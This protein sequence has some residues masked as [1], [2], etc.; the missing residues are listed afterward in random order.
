MIFNWK[1][2]FRNSVKRPTQL[3]Q[4]ILKI[5][6]PNFQDC[7]I[8]NWTVI[9]WTIVCL[10]VLKKIL[11]LFTWNTSSLHDNMSLYM[12]CDDQCV[13]MLKCFHRITV[14][15]MCVTSNTLNYWCRLHTKKNIWVGR[16]APYWF[17][18]FCCFPVFLLKLLLHQ[19]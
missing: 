3:S 5:S 9:L 17:T 11:W 7:F 4:S 8:I 1:S 2:H 16:F 19:W 13:V 6:S 18:N 10:C 15:S 12:D 14:W